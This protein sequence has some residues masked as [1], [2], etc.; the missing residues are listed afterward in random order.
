LM[1]PN[2]TIDAA[3][4][5]SLVAIDRGMQDLLTG[6]CDVALVGGVNCSTPAPIFMVFCQLNAL[7]RRG[8][9]QPFSK[10]ADGTLLGEGLGMLV[11]KRAADARRD[12]DRVYAVIKGVGV[13][14]DGRA[15]GLLAPRVD[16]EELSMR[17]AYEACA[18][19]P[20]TVGLLE[21]HG[22]GTAIGDQT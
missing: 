19:D 7:S 18:I 4:A 3:C 1:G 6:R 14:S 10:D 20:A 11:L 21:A 15:M 5:S 13:A 2:F 22:T 17:R 8:R 16:G 9:I 12:G